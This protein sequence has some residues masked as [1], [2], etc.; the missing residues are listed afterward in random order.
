MQTK[1]NGRTEDFSNASKTATFTE[2][3]DVIAIGNA[4]ARG[5]RSEMNLEETML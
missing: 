4:C 3:L 2:D 5:I 1:K